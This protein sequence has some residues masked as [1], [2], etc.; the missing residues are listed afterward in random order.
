MCETLFALSSACGKH[1]ERGVW[2]VFEPIPTAP[3]PPTHIC[4]HYAFTAVCRFLICCSSMRCGVSPYDLML[5]PY[6]LMLHVPPYD[7]MLSPYDLMLHGAPRCHA[8]CLLCAVR[9]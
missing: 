2:L 8:R 4:I 5:S 9:L 1:Y 6:D 7:L 3:L